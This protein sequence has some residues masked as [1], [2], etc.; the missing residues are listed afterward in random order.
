MLYI[1]NVKRIITDM[2]WNEFIK[3][4][5]AHGWRLERSGSRHDVYKHPERK[6]LLIIPRHG[7]EEIK[8]GLF[9]KLKKQVGI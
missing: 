3:I 4:A 7:A 5:K 2:K 6:D 8:T 1:C 9:N